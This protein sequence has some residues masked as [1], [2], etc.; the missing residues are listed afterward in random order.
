M[1]KKTD[2]EDYFYEQLEAAGMPKPEREF[3]FHPERRWRADFAW[4]QY[5]L[6]VEVEGWGRHQSWVGFK[7][8]VEKYNEATLMGYAVFR[9]TTEQVY[10][11]MALYYVEQYLANIAEI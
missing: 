3:R 6:I 1:S 8:D 11:D 9:V 4:P 2:A 5:M 10:Q 7:N